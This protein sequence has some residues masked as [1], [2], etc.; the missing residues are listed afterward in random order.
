MRNLIS[1][2]LYLTI[3]VTLLQ[4][5]FVV[6]VPLAIWFSFRVGALALLPVAILIDG[7]F[8]AFFEIPVLSIVTLLWYVVCELLRPQLLWQNEEYG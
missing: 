3:I 8:G 2:F 5:L 4:G 6:T 1:V 7:Y